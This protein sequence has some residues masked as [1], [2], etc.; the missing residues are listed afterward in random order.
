MQV[1]LEK[2]S[3]PGDMDVLE[4]ALEKINEKREKETFK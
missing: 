4:N 1:Q 2:L 3:V